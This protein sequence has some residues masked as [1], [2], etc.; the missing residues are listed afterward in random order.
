MN[1]DIENII[2]GCRRRQSKAQ[3]TLYE[4]FSARMYGVC[5]RYAGSREDAEDILHEGFMKVFGKIHQ[6]E[7]K[8]S[9]EGWIRRIMVNTAL[10]KYRNQYK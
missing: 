3:Q 4:L 9:F 2:E 6:F 1:T 10:E 7:G 5:L 8:G